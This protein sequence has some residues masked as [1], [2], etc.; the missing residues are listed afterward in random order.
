MA[1]GDKNHAKKDCPKLKNYC[2][3][4]DKL[5]IEK[6]ENKEFKENLGKRKEITHAQEKITMSQMTIIKMSHNPNF[7]GFLSRGGRF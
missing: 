2:Y 6:P 7:S 5:W 4:R 1:R 3:P